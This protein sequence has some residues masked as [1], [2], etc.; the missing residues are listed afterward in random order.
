M[1]NLVVV[2]NQGGSSVFSGAGEDTVFGS[3][4]NDTIE[5]E[6]GNDA[7]F[8]GD[9]ADSLTGGSGID[10][11]SGGEDDDSIVGGDAL[12]ILS[13]DAGNDD[14]SGDNGA[15]I[16][17]GGSGNDSLAGGA[18][19]DLLEGGTGDDTLAGGMGADF[20]SGDRGNDQ[21]LG[22]TENDALFGGDG[23]DSL[24]GEAGED[25]LAG[26]KGDDSL[27]GGSG[28]D[29]FAFQPQ[30]G[31]DTITDFVA[32]EDR[33]ELLHSNSADV[34]VTQQGSDV[35]INLD[36]GSLTVHSSIVSDVLQAIDYVHQ[37]G[38]TGGD[39]ILGH[40]GA[41][42]LL[43]DAGNDSVDG[44]AG[45]DFL[46]GGSGSDTISGGD[47][48][49]WIEGDLG[50][51]ILTGG[52][53]G[54]TFV[55]G[56]SSGNDTLNDFDPS[57]DLLIFRGLERVDLVVESAAGDPTS[58]RISFS[59]GSVLIA[60]VAASALPANA[61]AFEPEEGGNGSD[62]IAGTL[63]DDSLK[64]GFGADIVSGS[65]GDDSLEGEDGSDTLAGGKGDDTLVGGNDGDSLSGGRGNDNLAGGDGDDLLQGGLGSDRLTGGEGSD[66]LTFRVGDGVDEVTDFDAASDQLLLQVDD[67]A[68]ISVSVVNGDTVI[69]YGDGDS[70]QLT[71]VSAPNLVGDGAVIVEWFGTD[72]AETKSGSAGR[73][74][75][76][77]LDGNDSLSASTGNDDVYGGF[78]DDTLMGG[79]GED[80]LFGEQGDDQLNGG[81][82][83]DWIAGGG[84]S[85]TLTGGADRDIFFASGGGNDVV[86]DYVVGVDIVDF[87][88][89]GERDISVESVNGD[90]VVTYDDGSL[91]LV[92]A[93]GD[94]EALQ[95][96]FRFYL[97]PTGFASD[98]E[99]GG[100]GSDIIYALEGSDWIDAGDG[101]DAVYG[102]LPEGSRDGTLVVIRASGEQYGDPPKMQVSID[103]ATFAEIE[104]EEEFGVDNPGFYA[105][106]LTDDFDLN[107]LTIKFTNDAF[108]GTS[109]TDRN[110][111]IHE[112]WIEDQLVDPSAIAN[113]PPV[114][115]SADWNNP[116]DGV[117]AKLYDDEFTM[118][119]DLSL[120]EPSRKDTLIGGRGNDSLFGGHGADWLLGE[121]GDDQIEGQTGSDWLDGGAG[122]DLI[123]GG[124]G[125]DSFGFID[126]HGIDTITDFDQTED[127]IELEAID[128]TSLTIT[129]N[130]S[131]T[132]ITHAAGT[133][134]V[135]G[136]T[137][138]SAPADGSFVLHRRG[139]SGEDT[140][141]GVTIGE[142]FDGGAGN[143][144]L[145]GVG[146][147][148]TF[149]FEIGDG[150]DT[151]NDFDVTK[152]VVDL[153]RLTAADYEV[154]QVGSDTEISYG[155]NEDKVILTGVD[156]STLTPASIETDD[157]PTA[158]LLD[159]D[160]VLA[161]A[162]A[163]TVVG[164]LF[165]ADRNVGD[166]HTF[167]VVNDS[168]FEIDE[169]QLKL[170][171][172]ISLTG[173]A[174]TVVSV[175]IRAIDGSGLSL[176]DTIE[177]H[178]VNQLSVGNGTAEVLSV[179]KGTVAGL[180]GMGGDDTIYGDGNGSQD[181]IESGVGGDDA[182]GG[183]DGNDSLVGDSYWRLAG[184]G[185][186]GNDKL[187]GDAGNDT[188]QGDSDSTL[189]ESATGGN[190]T[191]I[192]GAGDDVIS[193]E[194][195]LQD[196][197]VGGN[198]WGDGGSGDDGLYGDGGQLT[199]SARGGNDTLEGGEGNDTLSGDSGSSLKDTALGGDDVL[200]GGAGADWLF[201]DAFLELDNFSQGGND[202]LDGGA[203]NDELRGDSSSISKDAVAGGRYAN[204]WIW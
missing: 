83:T 99:F 18:G 175:D 71:G 30:D 122:N 66:L 202:S 179:S 85:D 113:E 128:P 190:D 116:E 64:G 79:D 197:A 4:G 74:L 168:R 6:D 135:E 136:V 160:A 77:G 180:Y 16:L 95:S 21:L 193:G 47:G 8:G 188:L 82:G 20:L 7:I 17:L 24:I 198:D 196:N 72:G 124:E 176:T 127:V 14:I 61:F 170:K 134:V 98:V 111:I 118:V 39:T 172:G 50:D 157:A 192:G 162:N 166:T 151:I 200:S 38:S 41:N 120:V 201:G 75:L 11:I 88:L 27:T 184:T 73:D 9:G 139:T 80:R 87:G 100:P 146:G 31:D 138:S 1:S 29:V 101:D 78:G 52:S 189:E 49:D 42:V 93:G 159:V 65:D 199:G 2:A 152:D 70:I 10:Q 191:L 149:F 140:L 34:V 96:D 63:S 194:S 37:S 76:N 15:D 86:T 145:T 94:L 107:E 203:G 182:I 114:N 183:G 97:V 154:S 195:G 147:A 156:A 143:D 148:N 164:R 187:E 169:D 178:L 28:V 58:T 91:K 204:R 84:G 12:D 35:L 177:V 158:I 121:E 22:G 40:A 57:E 105:F 5:G 56:S 36:G 25:F 67:P 102:D 130:G 144:L 89:L 46:S 54:D 19:D 141:T 106:R 133:I 59:G 137:W 153:G 32:G 108:G 173:A 51:D 69:T 104:V 53:G 155:P 55:F 13:G 165:A 115:W 125:A 174:G 48:N 45:D 129:H 181:F 44:A 68:D 126:L 142:R 132:T 110:L 23:A 26:G 163:G 33:I 167:Q 161:G 131:D 171:E 81:S 62:T 60:G 90:A 43:A 109:E 112:I 119:V 123:S 150:V 92:G 185:K 103:G 3:V 117:F 186:G